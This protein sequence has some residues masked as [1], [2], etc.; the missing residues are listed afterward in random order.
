MM[1]MESGFAVDGESTIT[2]EFGSM[3]FLYITDPSDWLVPL[4]RV[5]H[6]CLVLIVLLLLSQRMVQHRV[7]T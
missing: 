2:D 6:C 3:S 4:R 7:N 5:T 1:N